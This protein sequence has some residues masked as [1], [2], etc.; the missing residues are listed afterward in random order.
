M[1]IAPIKSASTLDRIGEGARGTLNS[2]IADGVTLE[3]AM[4]SLRTALLADGKKDVDGDGKVDALATPEQITAL[5]LALQQ[6]QARVSATKSVAE[7]EKNHTKD[8]ARVA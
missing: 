4:M 6:A 2:L 8:M 3:A 7:A 1:S 5:N